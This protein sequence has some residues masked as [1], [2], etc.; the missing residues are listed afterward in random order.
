MDITQAVQLALDTGVV[1]STQSYDPEA[2]VYPGVAEV[3]GV[4]P[5]EISQPYYGDISTTLITDAA[6]KPRPAG[7]P[8]Q[9]STSMSGYKPMLKV[10]DYGRSYRIDWKLVEAA[11]ANAKNL[12]GNLTAAWVRDFTQGWIDLKNRMFAELLENGAKTAGSLIYDGSIGGPGGF[13][14]PNP[15]FGYDGK[16]WFATDHPLFAASGAYANH[17]TGA[18]LASAT[19]DSART[20][21]TSTNAVDEKG[22]RIMLR[23]GSLMVPPSLEGTARTILESQ[24]L[25]GGANNDVNINRGAASLVVNPYLTDADGWYLFANRRTIRVADSGAPKVL[26][27]YDYNTGCIVVT[28]EAHFG[29]TLRDWRGILARN[30]PTS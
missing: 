22:E 3:V 16:P 14:D 18:A 19:F 9:D 15:L 4:G 23:L 10:V 12:V 1:I 24:N 30:L 17:A 27:H 5:G 28:A 25:P 2:L 26:T 6:P 20:V 29:A 7:T 8:Y 13:V 21:M 11:G